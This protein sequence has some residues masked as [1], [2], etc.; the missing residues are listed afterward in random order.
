MVRYFLCTV[1]FL[2]VSITLVQ[3]DNQRI[4]DIAYLIGGDEYQTLDIY[5]PNELQAPL[6]ILFMVHGGGFIAGDKSEMH[7]TAEHY[8][9]LGY[10][11]I[12][13]NY[14]LAPAF[15][16]PTAH[17]D[18]FC[19]LAWT[20]A[21]ADE[22]NLDNSRLYLMGESAGANTIALLATMDAPNSLLTDCEHQL[23]E[24]LNIRAVFAMYM[25][26]D[27]ASCECQIA[28][29]LASMY[30]DVNLS[31]WDDTTTQALWENASIIHEL[32][33]N[34]PPFYLIH[35]ANDFLVPL[36]ESDYFVELVETVG[37]HAELVVF[38]GANHGFFTN[39]DSDYTQR[40]LEIIDKWLEDL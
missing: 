22:Y 40:A 11:V 9:N 17:A 35:G 23:P 10:A 7:G 30:L 26:V 27:L 13:P 8:A 6:P 20:L 16:Y 15:T 1:F 2:F 28:K 29:R 37:G 19:A 18:V 34:D 14:R 36:S 21:H 33:Q 32:D 3:A 5:L 39:I 31:D 4:Y 24:P 38:E 12:S 25:P